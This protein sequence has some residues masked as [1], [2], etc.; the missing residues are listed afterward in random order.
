M[1]GKNGLIG[2]TEK[3]KREKK[4]LTDSLGVAEPRLFVRLIVRER[5]T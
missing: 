5:L 1:K 2:K 3:E 4:E